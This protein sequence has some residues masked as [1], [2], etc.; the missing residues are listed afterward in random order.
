MNAIYLTVHIVSKATYAAVLVETLEIKPNRFIGIVTI[1]KSN[2]TFLVNSNQYNKVKQ[3]KQTKGLIW[4]I[5]I[6]I[7]W[8]YPAELYVHNP[9][10]V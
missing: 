9:N 8:Y 10:P 7:F 6:Y 2:P 4:E 1:K 3:N 5:T